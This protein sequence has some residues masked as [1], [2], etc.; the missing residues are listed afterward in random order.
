MSTRRRGREF[1]LKAL[2]AFEMGSQTREEIH[3]S[4]IGT[5]GLDENISD[6]AGRLFAA[7]VDHIEA[8]DRVIG[9]LT[10]NWKL[11][12]IAIVDKN[13]LRMAMAEVEHM[14]DIP[15]KVAINEAI[16]L[17]KKYS[18]MESAAFVNGILD[19]V[20]RKYGESEAGR[21]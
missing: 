5:S 2:Y 10:I 20:L 17:A 12:R 6:F 4:I 16:E 18:T 14:P 15:I 7:T 21:K 3:D 11:E 8:I 9:D 19:K 13:I 1:V